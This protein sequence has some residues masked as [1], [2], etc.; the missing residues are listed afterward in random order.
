M[1]LIYALISALVLLSPRLTRAEALE[2]G[3]YRLLEIGIQVDEHKAS[4]KSWDSPATG[5]DPTIR[6][7]AGSTEIGRCSGSDTYEHRCE[8]DSTFQYD[9]SEL[10]IKVVDRDIA[11]D[12][13][14]GKAR[15]AVLSE[16]AADSDKLPMEVEGQLT[17][18]YIR[19]G[20][21]PILPSWL[22]QYKQRMIGLLLGIIAAL[23]LLFA[24]KDFWFRKR[25]PKPK[26]SE[27]SV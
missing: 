17:A 12:D 13:S 24:F 8:F 2:S 7:Y 25:A 6:V 19:I 10:H 23:I 22:V 27:D 1:R 21:M 16:G 26:P 5:P 9:G 14:I 4:G 15:L 18:A 20:E 3:P 11:S